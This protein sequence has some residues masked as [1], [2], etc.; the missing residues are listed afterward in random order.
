MVLSL[1]PSLSLSLSVSVSVCLCL[2]VCLSLSLSV[3][4]SVSEFF[5]APADDFTLEKIIELGLDQFAEQISE[6]SGAASKELSIEQV[7]IFLLFINTS[8]VVW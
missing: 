1:S 6:I 8:S 3:S 5:C 2:S 7:C 4:V